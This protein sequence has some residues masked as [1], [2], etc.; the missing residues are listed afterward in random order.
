MAP[1]HPVPS[2]L[3]SIPSVPRDQLPL[4]LAPLFAVLG[5]LGLALVGWEL[6]AILLLFSAGEPTV[7]ALLRAYWTG[8]TV[9]SVLA[10]LSPLPFLGLTWLLYRLT[11]RRLDREIRSQSRNAPLVLMPFILPAIGILMWSALAP[12][13]TCAFCEEIAADI[14]QVEGENLE[15]ITVLLDER[16][17]PDTTFRDNPEGWQVSQRIVLGPDTNFEWVTLRFP[18]TLNFTPVP[19]SFVVIGGTCDWNWE[20]AQRY[21]VRCTS[22]FRLVTEITPV[23]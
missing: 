14:R 7:L 18:D 16:S 15:S 10:A 13:G 1:V 2:N 8:Y 23:D 22:N 4:F 11:A 21:Q 17:A 6:P 3:L 9:Y 20:H 12:G 5:V 19:D